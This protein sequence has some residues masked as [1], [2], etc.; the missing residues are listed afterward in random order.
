MAVDDRT[1][2]LRKI[3]PVRVAVTIHRTRRPGNEAGGV[4]AP[5]PA[6]AA[7]MVVPGA[8][9][10]FRNIMPLDIA[11]A[12]ADIDDQAIGQSRGLRELAGAR[13]Q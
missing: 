5:R 8:T 7:A 2:I 12:A 6:T 13:R 11:M 3:V 4:G 1:A 9:A 10:P